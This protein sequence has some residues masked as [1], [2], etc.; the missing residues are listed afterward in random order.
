MSR[1]IIFA[2]IVVEVSF[3][4]GKRAA[5][6]KLPSMDLVMDELERIGNMVERLASERNVRSAAPPAAELN[7][8]P[9]APPSQPA[10]WQQPRHAISYSM[11]GR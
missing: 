4:L 10:Q 3:S 5:L 8:P 6:K 11:F 9:A 2:L 7:P 1:A